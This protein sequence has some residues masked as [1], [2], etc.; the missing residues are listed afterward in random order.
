[1]NWKIVKVSL[2][3]FVN[4]LE[5]AIIQCDYVRVHELLKFIGDECYD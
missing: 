5:H 1:M 2:L 4:E 3:P